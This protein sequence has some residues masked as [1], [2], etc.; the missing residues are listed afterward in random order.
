MTQSR[1]WLCIVLAACF[2]NSSVYGAEIGPTDDLEA[3]AAAL[4]PGEE[5]VLRG[6][7]YFFDENVTITANGT[8]AATDY[9]S[10]EEW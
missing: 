6:G 5:L 4:S 3:A 9:Y 7:T 8:A 1:L 10:C 2:C